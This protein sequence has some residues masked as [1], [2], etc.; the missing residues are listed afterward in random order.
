MSMDAQYSTNQII[1]VSY[2]YLYWLWS[3]QYTISLL[4]FSDVCVCSTHNAV[5]YHPL[6]HKPLNSSNYSL[7]IQYSFSSGC[8]SL[9]SLSSLSY[10]SH[11]TLFLYLCSLFY[12]YLCSLSNP[13]KSMSKYHCILI[14]KMFPNISSSGY[15]ISFSISFFWNLFYQG[16]FWIP[17][18]YLWSV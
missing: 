12:Q 8:R 18:R 9:D 6:I 11:S 14:Y 16:S 10:T 15:K 1:P 3:P 13:P 7:L 5:Y 17:I 2:S 4:L